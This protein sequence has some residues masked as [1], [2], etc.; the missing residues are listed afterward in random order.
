MH[1]LALY[2]SWVAIWTLCSCLYVQSVDLVDT[3]NNAKSFHGL[4]LQAQATYA[5]A[6]PCLQDTWMMQRLN[7][8]S[9][10]INSSSTASA[11]WKLPD[12][13]EQHF[14]ELKKIT[15]E[16]RHYPLH[17]YAG[18]EGPWL[19]NIF[20]QRFLD[21]PLSYFNGFIPIFIQWI[22]GQI[23]RGHHFDNVHKALNQHLRSGV[24]YLAVSRGD[25]GLGKIGVAHPN[26]LVLSAGGFGRA[27]VPLVKGEVTYIHPSTRSR[28]RGT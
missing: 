18:Y 6:L 26:I 15:A 9:R 23:L 4:Q 2:C 16:F 3:N 17:R 14:E 19:E 24:T 20:I 27:P 28:C 12:D 21:K 25:V 1:A 5:Q 11:E 7:M 13:A 8:Q 22:D 10:D